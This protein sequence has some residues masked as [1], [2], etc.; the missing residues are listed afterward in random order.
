MVLPLV[1]TKDAARA[2]ID[3]GKAPKEAIKEVCYLINGVPNPP[4]AQ[5]LAEM[6][7]AKIPEARTNFEPDPEWQ[8][9]LE[10]SALLIDDKYAKNEWGWQ[11]TFD[12]YDKIIDDFIEAAKQ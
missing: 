6:V 8:R 7:K 10:A 5:E 12:T 11:P 1:H 2:I 9:V 4:T 3:L